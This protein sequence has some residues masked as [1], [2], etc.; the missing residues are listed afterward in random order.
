MHR[1]ARP[2][3][4]TQPE[5]LPDL[6]VARHPGVELAPET[7]MAS[8]TSLGAMGTTGTSCGH[9]EPE[10]LRA[11]YPPT[12]RYCRAA[13]SRIVN[14]QTAITILSVISS[15]AGSLAILMFVCVAAWIVIS[16]GS[17]HSPWQ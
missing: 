8:S 17:G 16:T 14:R 4:I 2:W 12:L 15:L 10:H 13:G 5:V 7:T 9:K 6:A 1:A 11:D 3:L